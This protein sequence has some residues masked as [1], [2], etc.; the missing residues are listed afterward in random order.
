MPRQLNCHGMCKIMTWSVHYFSYE[1]WIMSL[2][3]V[4]EMGPKT[5]AMEFCIRCTN[6]WISYQI[7]E[8]SPFPHHPGASNKISNHPKSVL[9][10]WQNLI[11]FI[12]GDNPFDWY[13]M[14]CA[15]KKK[16]KKINNVRKFVNYRKNYKQDFV[17]LGFEK[18]LWFIR[19]IVTGPCSVINY[20]DLT[21]LGFNQRNL[22]RFLFI[23]HEKI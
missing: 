10:I 14:F 22:M 19:Y 1:I 13:I 12:L 11:S 21:S 8:S 5:K 17:G 20:G 18:D 23:I 15:K 9:D 2:W 7:V 3:T 4:C 6:S 16:R